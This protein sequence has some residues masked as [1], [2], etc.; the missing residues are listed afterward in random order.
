LRSLTSNGQ[1]AFS[2][3]EAMLQC[4]S[5]KVAHHVNSRR[6]SAWL[7]LARS[8]HEPIGKTGCIG[9]E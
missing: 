3:I 8:G 1:N 9:R 6:R 4:K 2:K 5:L 7:L